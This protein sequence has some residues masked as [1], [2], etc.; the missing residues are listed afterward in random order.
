MVRPVAQVDVIKHCLQMLQIRFDDT[1]FF[2]L[3]ENMGN[4]APCL[5]LQLRKLK[6]LPRYYQSFLRCFPFVLAEA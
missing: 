6:L 1:P 4:D 3:S 2:V 5:H